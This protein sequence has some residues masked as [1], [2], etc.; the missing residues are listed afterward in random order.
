VI[1]T[2]TVLTNF[3]KKFGTVMHIS[4][5][6]LMGEQMFENLKTQDGGRRPS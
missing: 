1:I 4:H 5:P 3:D 6:N 2:A